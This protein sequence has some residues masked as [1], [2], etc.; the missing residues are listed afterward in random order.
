MQNLLSSSDANRSACH[1]LR[2]ARTNTVLAR[3]GGC[4]AAVRDQAVD[5]AL[6]VRSGEQATERRRGVQEQQVQCMYTGDAA[7]LGHSVVVCASPAESFLCLPRRDQPRRQHPEADEP[8]TSSSIPDSLPVLGV[9]SDWRS[10][11][12]ARPW[13]PRTHRH[14]HR[15]RIHRSPEGVP[16]WLYYGADGTCCRRVRARRAQLVAR[17]RAA[18]AA[19]VDEQEQQ[20]GEASTSGRSTSTATSMWAHSLPQPEK[21]CVLLAHPMMFTSSQEYF[22][23]AVILILGRR[24]AARARACTLLGDRQ[25]GVGSTDAFSPRARHCPPHLADHSETGSFGIILNRPSMVSAAFLF[26]R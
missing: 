4:F 20:Q 6:A 10:F 11:R 9:D 14:A 12:R 17:S 8:S 22:F 18:A 1:K 24:A 21:G 5:R 23:Q 26:P 3:L 16:Q 7:S 15:R 25:P 19:A 13:R 2:D